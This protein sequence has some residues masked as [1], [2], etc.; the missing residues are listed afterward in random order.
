MYGHHAPYNIKMWNIGNEPWTNSEFGSTTTGANNYMAVASPIIDSMLTVD[1]TL[2]ITIPLVGNSGSAW[3]AQIMNPNP[4]TP[5]LGRIYS[6]SPHS[7]YDNDPST[8]N[9]NPAQVLS[10]FSNIA[11]T[12]NSMGIK[13]V[14]GDHAHEAPASDPDKGMR[15]EGALATGDALLGFSQISNI[16][17]A[18]FWIYGNTATTWHPI[19]KNANGTYTMMAT[20]Q[21][22]ESFFLLL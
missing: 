20:A 12:A 9:P 1:S 4:P 2:H 11:N 6:V 7:F 5:L 3:N 8:G 16:E 19:R 17:L 15:W 18:N 10:S 14:V 13:V 22:Y 21:L